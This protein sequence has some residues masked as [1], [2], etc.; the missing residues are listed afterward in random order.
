[1]PSVVEIRILDDND[2]VPELIFT[3]VSTMTMEDSA[4]WTV[5]ALFKNTESRFG[6]KWGGHMSDTRKYIFQNVIFL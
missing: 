5:I 2:K 4:L 6:E 3:S 1:M